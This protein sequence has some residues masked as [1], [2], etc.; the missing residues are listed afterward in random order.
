MREF[1]SNATNLDDKNLLALEMQINSVASADIPAEA[2]RSA[3]STHLQYLLFHRCLRIAIVVFPGEAKTAWTYTCRPHT[4][5][6]FYIRCP[7]RCCPEGRQ[8]R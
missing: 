6:T 8:Q 2:D 5:A 7:R 1:N 4:C 3:D